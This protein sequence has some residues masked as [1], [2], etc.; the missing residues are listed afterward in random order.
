M[1]KS[2]N[3]QVRA[4]AA[5]TKFSVLLMCFATVLAL[6][7]TAGVFDIGGSDMNANVADAASGGS[8]NVYSLTSL[9]SSQ[10][11]NDM[12]SGSTGNITYTIDFAQ[13][14]GNLANYTSM[15]IWNGQNSLSFYS[16]GEN[17]S[18]GVI[19]DSATTGATS[20]TAIAVLN[21][22]VPEALLAYADKYSISVS[23][24]ASLYTSSQGGSSWRGFGIGVVGSGSALAG[25]YFA[26]DNWATHESNRL[27][28]ENWGNQ[29]L[30]D[31]G[32]PYTGNLQN[33]NGE[34][35][36]L[37][38]DITNLSIVIF[39]ETDYWL[40][41][42]RAQRRGVYAYNLKLTF[43]VNKNAVLGPSDGNGPQ[44]ASQPAP[45]GTNTSHELSHPRQQ[46]RLF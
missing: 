5:I 38:K 34:S 17:G 16:N 26:T 1:R 14:E 8:T 35:T 39:R 30:I 25:S 6:V 24:S 2:R 40:I 20:P 13:S 23:A 15:E 32:T 45:T 21:V 19:E 9:G 43:T 28:K 46:G 41:S 31:N 42:S 18:F 10:I 22:K 29:G 7:L 33:T 3:G 37:N 11:H 27:Y 36:T 44:V 4:F 12:H